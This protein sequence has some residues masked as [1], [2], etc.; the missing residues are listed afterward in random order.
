MRYLGDVL[1][2]TPLLRSIRS[3]YPDVQL[4]VLVFRNTAAMLEGNPDINSVIT[5]P[6]RPKFADYIQLL[7][8][9]FRH[10]DLAMVTQTG[11]R[12]FLYSVLA[13][14]FRIAV[15]PPR[16]TTGWWKR[17]FI[18][19]WTEFD[20]I[21]THTV[22]QNLKLT[23]MLGI[24]RNYTL[25]PPQAN[26]IEP[27]AKRFDF[28]AGDTGYVVLH[29]HP[30]WVYKRW[31]RESWIEIGHYL[32]K[33]GLKLIVSGGSAQK[34]KDYVAGIAAELPGDTVNIAGLVS[35]AQLAYIIAQARLFIGP[36]TGITHLAAATG[37]PV[38]ALF[39]PTNPVKWGPWPKGFEQDINPFEKKG[40][41]QVNNISLIQ[42][43]GDCVPCYLE[44]CDRHRL[45][46][47][48]CLDT[49]SAQKVK[50]VIAATLHSPVS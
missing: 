11:D 32:N 29:M 22:L 31:T 7:P 18:Q 34:E 1:L 50:Q 45:S 33:L 10:Y 28:L 6:N 39:G 43:E 5:T 23:D 13:A 9:L 8:R 17:F 41:Q 37:I 21:D 38:I 48:H 16:N 30:Q 46:R 24:A 35:L 12:P 26:P 42:G 2:I 19:C 49:L 36:D 20:N 25:T 47:S 4:D 3:A 44:G 14:P 40:S 27:L 15:V